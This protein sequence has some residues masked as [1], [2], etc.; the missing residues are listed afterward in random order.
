[1]LPA[2]VAL[3]SNTALPVWVKPSAGLPELEDGKPVYHCT[4]DDFAAGMAPLLK[5]GANIVGGCCGI[6]PR[7]VK[8]LGATLAA[9]PL[10]G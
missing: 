2:V 3:R 1:V 10:K 4:P 8:R 6:G 7:H 9:R 5:A